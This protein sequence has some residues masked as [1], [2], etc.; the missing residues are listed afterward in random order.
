MNSI[1]FTKMCGAGNDFIIVQ[2]PCR[3][4]IKKLALRVCHRTDGIGADGLIVIE[5]S[6]KAN[7]KMRIINADGSEAEMCGNGARCMAAYLFSTHHIQKTALTMET[8]A[9]IIHATRKGKLI[10][11]GLSDPQDYTKNISLV[12]NTRKLRLDYINTG[13]P[14]AVCFVRGLKAIDVNTIGRHIRYHH[15]FAPKGTNVNFVEEMGRNFI[16]VRTYERGV[17]AETRAC[18]TGSVASAVIAY[19]KA[20]PDIDYKKAAEI[21]VR[22]KSGEV[23]K[24]TFDFCKDRISNVWLTGSAN[25]IAEGKLLLNI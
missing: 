13:V 23:L 9:G 5:P 22:T 10:S 11:V 7:A 4:D 8:L 12:I 3:V 17:E 18:G 1:K 21:K 14:H 24:V 2:G 19:L 25:F 15:A 16:D 6:K 20:N